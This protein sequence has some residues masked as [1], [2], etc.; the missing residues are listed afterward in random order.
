MI[1]LAISPHFLTSKVQVIKGSKIENKTSFQL[2]SNSTPRKMHSQENIVV[3]Y[4]VY[5]LLL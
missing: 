1:Y 4:F 2:C 3:F 5:V